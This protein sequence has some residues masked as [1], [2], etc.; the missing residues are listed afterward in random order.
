MHPGLHAS[1][2]CG[3]RLGAACCF[4][5][6]VVENLNLI[7]FDVIPGSLRF[8]FLP[9]GGVAMVVSSSAKCGSGGGFAEAQNGWE[10]TVMVE[11]FDTGCCV[12]SPR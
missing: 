9:L 6:V 2:E 3:I 7:T 8:A 5:V 4:L 11:E 10:S 1:S 12:R